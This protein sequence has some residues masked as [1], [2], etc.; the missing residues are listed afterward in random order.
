MLTMNLFPIGLTEAELQRAERFN[1][2]L[3]RMLTQNRESRRM[4]WSANGTGGTKDNRLW[5]V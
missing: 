3:E 4:G 2:G 1:E 5:T